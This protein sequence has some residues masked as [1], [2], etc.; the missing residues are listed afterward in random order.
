MKSD[1]L[2]NKSC[3]EDWSPNNVVLL[4]KTESIYCF[5]ETFYQPRKTKIDIKAFSKGE[6][7][8]QVVKGAC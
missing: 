4:L 8:D 6:K 7:K 1:I 5:E 2:I 3:Y